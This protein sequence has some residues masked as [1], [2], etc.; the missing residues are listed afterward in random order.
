MNYIF[1]EGDYYKK[2]FISHSGKDEKIARALSNFLESVAPSVEV[3]CSSQNGSIMV[4]ENFVQ[5]FTSAMENCD[6]FI[7]L[8]SENYYASRFC[9]IELGFA[10]SVLVQSTSAE[11][12]DIFPVVIP[13]VKKEEALAHT[14][15][16]MLHVSSIHDSE[17]LRECLESIFEN[18]NVVL[19]SGMNRRINEFVYGIKQQIFKKYD[20]NCCAKHLICKSQDVRGEDCDYLRYSAIPDRKGYTVNFRARPF[21]KSTEYPEFLSFVYQYVDK[22]DLYEP[23]LLFEDSCLKVCIN[24]FTDSISKIDIEIK[25]S[26]NNAILERRTISLAAGENRITIPLGEIKCEALRQVSEVCFVIKPSAYVEEEGM[27]QVYDFE[28]VCK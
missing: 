26:D 21:A 28:L 27:F 7:P 16:A 1:L 20:I 9:M 2:I 10:Y 6:A 5:S 13:P 19:K 4:G 18:S 15:L 25:H 23:V 14:P 8:L 3:Y 24:N 12:Y 11:H 22:L 17:G